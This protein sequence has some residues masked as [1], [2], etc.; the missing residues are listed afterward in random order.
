MPRRFNQR[1]YLA[2]VLG[3]LLIA[4]SAACGK[5]EKERAKTGGG[6]VVVGILSEPNSLNPLVAASAES[7]DIVSLMF[8]KLLDEEPDFL[9]FKPRLADTWEFSPD[10]LE[11]TFHLRSGAVW[12]NGERVTA[13]DVRFTWEL[14]TDSVVA[15][16]SRKL[17]DRIERVDVLDD[18]TVRF[19][20]TNR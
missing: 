7:Q 15:W 14:Q 6:T 4:G 10:S 20:F 19:R 13:D 17:K 11:I 8:L 12:Q 18:L 5:R 3:F 1:L 9:H 2:L 16:A